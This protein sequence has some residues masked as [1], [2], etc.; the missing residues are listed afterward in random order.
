MK[1]PTWRVFVAFAA[2]YLAAQL[3][4]WALAPSGH[5]SALV[6][7]ACGVAVLGLLL[8]GWRFWPWLAACSWLLPVLQH[9]PWPAVLLLSLLGVAQPMLIAYALQGLGR[10]NALTVPDAMRF[11]AVAPVAVSGLA[12]TLAVLVIARF[13]PALAGNGF[14]PW[15]QLWLSDALG[16]LA[17]VP[18]AMSPPEAHH[19]IGPER[20]IE[21]GLLAI[22]ALVGV[23]LIYQYFSP[24]S[25][26]LQFMLFPLIIWSA[27]RSGHV[28]NGAIVL[29]ATFIAEIAINLR[30]Y[31]NVVELSTLLLL[32]SVAITGFLLAVSNLQQQAASRA[33]RLAAQVFENASE[34]ILITDADAR[35][36]AVNPAFSR[37]TGFDAAEAIGKTSRIFD[38]HGRV[39]EFNQHVLAQLSEQGMWQGETLDRR[40]NGEIYPAWLSISAVRDEEGQISNYVGVFSDYTS[41][42]EAEQRL[43]FLANH[44]ALTGLQNRVAMAEA[45]GA[46]MARA[47]AGNEQLALF[48]I[49]LDGFKPINDTYGHGVGDELL[50]V[51]AQRLRANLKEGDQI[52]R[53]GGDEFTIL[54]EKVQFDD[55]L[56]AVAQRLLAEL[57]QPIVLHEQPMLVSASIGIAR[58]PQDADDP[59]QLLKVAD[60]AM[61]QAKQGGKNKACFYTPPSRR[62]M[63]PLAQQ[64]E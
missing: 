33:K 62:A 47:S 22:V 43:Q 26:D 50:Q 12:A 19:R 29:G 46:A 18:L 14:E 55:E 59:L 9:M 64:C 2:L 34:G 27:L 8:V 30:G 37:V 58:Y 54:L 3:L 24:G 28:G 53:L 1:Q 41:R 38:T 44:D 10:V 40:K 23:V 48:F 15:A 35:I 49:D 4:T 11:I 63:P 13:N 42:K 17:I 57:A 5:Y 25:A 32:V 36:V 52:A 7:P 16:L 6:A 60:T 45:L 61:Y 51:I 21:L 56:V 39:R 20:Q 31:Y